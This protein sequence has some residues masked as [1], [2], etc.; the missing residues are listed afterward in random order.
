MKAASLGA[1]AAAFFGASAFAQTQ[2]SLLTSREPAPPQNDLPVRVTSVTV[3]KRD[4]L[5]SVDFDVVNDTDVT[6]TSWRVDVVLHRASGR[7]EHLGMG[8][9]ASFGY[10]WSTVQQ[11]YMIPPHS[12][13]RLAPGELS[14]EPG[15]VLR[16][17]A[18][19]VCAIFSDTTWIGSSA[20]VD[21]VLRERRKQYDASVLALAVMR[22]T[23]AKARGREALELAIRAL[24]KAPAP[25][26][27]VEMTLRYGL[28]KGHLD[29]AG[30]DR[31][32]ADRIA[33][34]E[35]GVAA[36]ERQLQKG[37]QA[38]VRRE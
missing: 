34:Y 11:P 22:D 13:A 30:A 9:D 35:K 12:S 20:A 38:F 17:E 3:S 33:E 5:T 29:S 36:M 10:G 1:I 19:L 31:L 32:L 28:E 23:A 24:E 27:G 8:T 37:P 2:G 21:E 26:P 16:V 4:A 18:T 7:P 25:K 15:E 6:V 14:N